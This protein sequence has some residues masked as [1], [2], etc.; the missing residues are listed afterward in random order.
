[1][2]APGT[3]SELFTQLLSI[4][5]VLDREMSARSEVPILICRAL[6]LKGVDTL[7]AVHLL[8]EASLPTQAQVLI[9]VLLEVRMDLDLFFTLTCSKPRRCS[10]AHHR[11]FGAREGQTATRVK[12]PGSGIR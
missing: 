4:C 12:F 1:M 8:Y 11:R 6:F 10:T 2:K 7:R 3:W 9:R 5:R